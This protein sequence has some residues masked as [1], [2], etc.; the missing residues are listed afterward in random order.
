MSRNK[1]DKLLSNFDN[2]RIKD[3]YEK[4]SADTLAS[5]NHEERR[6]T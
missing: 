4:E 5:N 6:A 1:L 3:K 2:V